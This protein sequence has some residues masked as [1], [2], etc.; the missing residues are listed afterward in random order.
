MTRRGRCSARAADRCRWASTPARNGGAATPID[1]PIA[2]VDLA[3]AHD[4][5]IEW[6]ATEVRL[7][8]RRRAGPDGSRR[9]HAGAASS[10]Q[11]PRHARRRP[12]SGLTIESMVR[13]RLPA[14]GTLIS[15]VFD[16]A[17]TRAAWGTLTA[18]GGATGVVFATRSGNTAAP[19]AS[20]SDWANT[21]AAGAIAS[22]AGRYMQYRATLTTSD[23]FVSPTLDGVEIGY[24]DPAPRAAIDGVDVSGTTAS[25]RFSSPD[26]DVDAVGVQPRRRRVRR[27]H[28]PEG[29]RRP[30]RRRAQR[31]RARGRQERPAAPQRAPRS[32]SHPL[33]LPAVA[34]AVALAEGRP[35]RPPVAARPSRRRSP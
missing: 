32:R 7:L 6:T 31:R 15:R 3:L 19:D 9:D 29:V 23:P 20:W 26:G 11:R 34:L 21:G 27:V 1:T 17:D 8:H 10:D 14:S 35:R 4:F 13:D 18:T 33:R 2:G 22:P 12:A 24:D 25:A 30:R 5:K 16:S 28:E